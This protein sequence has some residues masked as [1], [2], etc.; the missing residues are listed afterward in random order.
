MEQYLEPEEIAEDSMYTLYLPNMS[1]VREIQFLTYAS[2]MMSFAGIGLTNYILKRNSE[3]EIIGSI[4]MF[5]IA[6]FFMNLAMNTNVLKF[7]DVCFIQSRDSLHRVNFVH[8]NQMD[9]YAFDFTGIFRINVNDLSSDDVGIL[10]HCIIQLL[11]DIE[12]NQLLDET[13]KDSL[14]YDLSQYEVIRETRNYVKVSYFDFYGV[15]KTMKIYK[16]YGKLFA[17]DKPI[18]RYIDWRFWMITGLGLLCM[19]LDVAFY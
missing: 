14:I 17:E 1:N 4:C 3:L 2:V 16:I 19:F 13:V 12:D 15:E 5:A 18:K 8:L 6:C 11:N 10:K 9:Q 7:G